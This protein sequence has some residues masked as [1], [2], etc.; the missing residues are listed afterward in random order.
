MQDCLAG[1]SADPL[2]TLDFS[3]LDLMVGRLAGSYGLAA[4]APQPAA[5]TNTHMP[6]GA[7]AAGDDP[8]RSGAS[9]ETTGEGAFARL[10]GCWAQRAC[11]DEG[12]ART[13]AHKCEPAT[14][15]RELAR[16][17]RSHPPCIQAPAD[18]RWPHPWHPLP[19]V[20]VASLSV[21]SSGSR[22]GSSVAASPSAGA[23]TAGRTYLPGVPLGPS[24]FGAD[25][26]AG[27]SGIW[28]RYP[29]A[30]EQAPAGGP[31]VVVE[32]LAP[33][34][35]LSR[36]LVGFGSSG[37]PAPGAAV[38]GLRAPAVVT[39]GDGIRKRPAPSA[40][41]EE[42]APQQPK[43][44]RVKLP[45]GHAGGGG[46]ATPRSPGTAPARA[47][48]PKAHTPRRSGSAAAV[49][50]LAAAC[51]GDVPPS[52]RTATARAAGARVV[53]AEQLLAAACGEGGGAADKGA[54][55]GAAA[56][57]RQAS[58]ARKPR[59][60][61]GAGLSPE[62]LPEIPAYHE[63]ETR[64]DKLARYRA[65]KLRR[66]FKRTVRYECRK[67]RRQGWWGWWGQSA[68]GGW[69]PCKRAAY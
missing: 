55:K 39:T 19:A 7:A 47:V 25:V 45:E 33:R 21:A 64:A 20:L 34:V 16:L 30:S 36:S 56:V 52:P 31:M 61:P 38:V 23:R 29:P 15:S 40:T 49:A 11:R 68:G 4:A 35:T 22:P 24:P 44:I 69:A 10:P 6:S 2:P 54:A 42:Q 51:G 26:P 41:S 18:T 62:D 8:A 28:L 5:P 48:A 43:R 63:G 66:R 67:V 57:R 32:Q 50:A 27:S 3:G 53:Q 65:K 13:R 37:A 58:R 12:A 17:G 14:T 9:A 1:L 46:G 59:P 60:L